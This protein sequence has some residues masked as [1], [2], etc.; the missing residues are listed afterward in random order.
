[1]IQKAVEAYRMV[2]YDQSVKCINDLV[3]DFKVFSEENAK[4]SFFFNNVIYFI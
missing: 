4:V 1:M 2:G 3:E